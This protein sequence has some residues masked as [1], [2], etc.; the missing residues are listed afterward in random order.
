[1]AD[2][3]A[4]AQALDGR[5]AYELRFPAGALPPADAFWSVSMYGA[6]RFFVPN[7]IG[8]HAVGDRTRGLE[9][10][11]DGSLVIPIGHA[12]PEARLA[13]WLPA[14]PG[15]FYLILRVYHPRPEFLE[16]RYAIPPVVRVAA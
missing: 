4:D 1:M 13:N 12:A 10:E 6:D 2:F 9:R 7:V 16:G 11:A 3:D 8:R 14:P 15:P 5:H